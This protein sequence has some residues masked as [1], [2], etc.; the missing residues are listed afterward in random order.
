MDKNGFGGRLRKIRLSKNFTAAQLAEAADLS[1]NH[2]RQLEANRKFPRLCTLIQLSN[3]LE[4]A[5]DHLLYDMQP[6]ELFISNLS[7]VNVHSLSVKELDLLI[8]TIDAL[9][10]RVGEVF[11][12]DKPN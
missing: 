11:D 12:G 7:S 8:A 4:V 10:K 5:P 2:I 6:K 9:S 1:E 3:A